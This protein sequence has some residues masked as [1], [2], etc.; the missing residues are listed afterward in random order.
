MCA[1]ENKCDLPPAGFSP[2]ISL[3]P[4][5]LL[6]TSQFRHLVFDPIGVPS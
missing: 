1:R 5:P 4:R 3:L 2:T 6:I